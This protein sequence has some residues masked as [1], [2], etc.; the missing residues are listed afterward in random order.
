MAFF[1]AIDAGTTAIKAAIINSDGD[2][3]AIDRQEYTLLIPSESRVELDA[4]IYWTNCC[5]A[6]R[7]VIAQSCVSPSDIWA[8]SISSQGETIIPLNRKGEPIGNAIVWLD[9]RAVDEALMISERF[10]VEVIQQVSGQTEISPIWPACKILWMKRNE[11]ER[12]ERTAKILLVEDYLL[13]RMTGQYVSNIAVHSS[14]LFVDI[15][16]R[17]WWQPMFDYIGISQDIFGQLTE[18]GVIVGTLSLQAAEALSLSHKT[19]VVSGGL[20]QTISAVGAGNIHEGIVSECT[21]SALA[22]IVS[23]SQPLFDPLRRVPCFYHSRSSYYTL[24]PWCQ[25]AGMALRWFRDQFYHLESELARKAHQ[26]PYDVMT[27]P[28]SEIP[29]GCDGLIVLPHLEGASCP[30]LNPNAKGVFFGLTLRHTRAHFVR[31]IMES[32]AFML[33]R[34]LELVEQMSVGISEIRS[35]GGAARNDEWLQIKADVLQKPILTVEN[36]EAACLGAA[37]IAAVAIG[38]YAN[39]QESVAGMV[40]IRRRVEPRLDYAK[41]Y[42]RCYE[43]YIELYDRLMPMFVS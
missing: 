35:T 6:V 43:R 29:P 17:S 16:S 40:R 10:G 19:I 39:L 15:K 25:T 3:L 20:D 11:P 13:F 26:D 23:L 41:V 27:R 37:M 22:I 24:M 36:E 12:F 42:R 32:V 14:T 8:V 9:N 7:N 31:A 1:L 28:V 2:L 4:E 33:L 21:G 34:N 30:E 5:Q 38:T 18:P